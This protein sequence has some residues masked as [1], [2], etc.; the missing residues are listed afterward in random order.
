M[1]QVVKR[2]SCCEQKSIS[3]I[4][5]CWSCHMEG[6]YWTL[7][8]G[9]VLRQKYNIEKI[10]LEYRRKI[11][12]SNPKT[13]LIGNAFSITDV[14]IKMP[15][16]ECNKHLKC[17]ESKAHV[18]KCVTKKAGCKWSVPYYGRRHQA[19]RC[20]RCRPKQCIKQVSECLKC[21]GE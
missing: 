3:T 10:N 7:L 9:V 2:G 16:L 20:S 11:L 21:F 15:L 19:S 4:M 6:R 13:A 17:I 8:T 12:G 14:N 18:S 5:W 1:E